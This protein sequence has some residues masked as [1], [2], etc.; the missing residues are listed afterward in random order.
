MALRP[1]LFAALLA[2]AGTAAHAQ[3]TPAPAVAPAPLPNTLAADWWNYFDATGDALVARIAAFDGAL[4][5]LAQRVRDDPDVAGRDV[6][7]PMLAEVR[8]LARRLPA[9]RTRSAPTPE[10]LPPVAQHYGPEQL[11]SF[12]TQLREARLELDFERDEMARQEPS[13]KAANAQINDAKAA[14]LAL[15]PDAPERL[16]AGLAI[17]R[18]R[19]SWA[20]RQ[21]DLRLR[22]AR[23][24]HLTQRVAALENRVATA[25]RELEVDADAVRKAGKALQAAREQAARLRREATQLRLRDPGYGESARERAVARRHSQ[26]LLQVEADTARADLDA[27]R[28]ALVQALARVASG[29]GDDDAL[30][31]LREAHRTLTARTQAVTEQGHTW[32]LATNRERGAAAA[33]LALA[34]GSDADL[35]RV[36]RERIERADATLTALNRL[37][38]ELAGS[39]LVLEAAQARLVDEGGH[40]EDVLTRTED[41]LADAWETVR[42]WSTA[43]MFEIN[44]TPVTP[45]GLLRVALIL[46]IAWWVAKG[47]G[48]AIGTLMDRRDTMSRASL[49]TLQRLSTYVILLVGFFVGLSS[50]G[51]DF[52][53]FALVISALG[54]GL[55][56]GLQ[57]IFSNFVAGLIILFEKSLKVGDF[58]ELESGV[59]GEVREIN[60]RSTLITTNDNIDILVPNSEFVNGRVTNWTLRE[61]FRRLR[62]PFGVAYGT[63]KDLVKKAALEAAEGV[64][65]TLKNS[66]GRE[67]KVW[68]TG[69]GDSSLDFELVVWLTT[70]AVKRPSAVQAAYTWELESALA[71]HGIEIPFPQ[72]DLHLRSGFGGDGAG[73]LP[74]VAAGDTTAGGPG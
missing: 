60:I 40:L 69:F 61:A 17:M 29:S 49:Y 11:L 71:R 55:G 35:A 30:D 28:A 22:R 72:R 24:E 47:V 23:V 43:S 31:A 62:V 18:D 64:P 16:A 14:Y 70:D 57:A 42:E 21:Q 68:L 53:K 59:N 6:A 10:P 50:I 45:V 38:Q 33:Q 58:V 15:G 20:L 37:E 4:G 26:Q 8:E 36:H 2:L 1:L 63:D 41:S 73:A 9:A 34:D 74:P 52:T 3:T 5:S 48:G 12:G 65:F 44:E 67:P 7:L 32:R 46:F 56:F 51:I 13:L 54:V 27:D 25:A 66:P 39:S 19:L